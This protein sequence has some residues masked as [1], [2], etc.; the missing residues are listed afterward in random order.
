M[1]W[2]TE[3]SSWKATPD[4][5]EL[6]TQG[7]T[8]FWR[9]THDNGD[10]HNGHFYYDV[11]RGNHAV[12]V[13][14]EGGFKDL[15]DQAG[16]MIRIDKENWIKCGIEYMNGVHHRSCVV[17]RGSSD[18]SI[19]PDDAGPSIWIRLARSGH[20]VEVSFSPDGKGWLLHRQAFFPATDPVEIG[21]M[22]ASPSGGGF[23]VRF[24]HFTDEA[25]ARA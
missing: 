5:I 9:I 18:W 1:K 7:K 6:Q 15:Y 4:G 16:L 25:T 14:V 20:T 17:T 22:A 12:S 10:R 11:Y 19:L 3:P 24:S 8:D 2:F 13:R 23:P 21:F